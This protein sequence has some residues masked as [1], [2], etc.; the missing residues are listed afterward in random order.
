MHLKYFE[1]IVIYLS[2]LLVCVVGGALARI[3]FLGKGGDEYTANIVFWA[4]TSLSILFYALII[5]FLDGIII[6]FRK[7]FPKKGSSENSTIDFI[8]SENPENVGE[9][10]KKIIDG[11]TPIYLVENSDE[12]IVNQTK[13]SVSLDS[14][15]KTQLQQKQQNDNVKLQIA[16]DYTRNQ[17]AL[18]LTDENLDVLCNAVSLYSKKEGISNVIS[19]HTKGLTNLD[20]YHFGWNIWNYFRPIKQEEISKL[21]KT[22][23]VSLDDIDLDSIKS[24]LKDEPQKGNIKIQEDLTDYQRT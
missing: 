6:L 14:I 9:K 19:V 4:I 3:S 16:L 21:L 12:N 11:N 2:V 5:L 8:R 17:F 23:F 13:E 7:I 20:L 10:Q 24:H 18:Y 15:R 1:Y 22:V